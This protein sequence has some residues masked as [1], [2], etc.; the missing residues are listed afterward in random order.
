[1]RRFEMKTLGEILVER[2]I[3]TRDQLN[4]AM[5]LQEPGRKSGEALVDL[6]II[7][8][9]EFEV[10][11]DLLLAEILVGLG[12]ADERAIFGSSRIGVLM[13]SETSSP[14]DLFSNEGFSDL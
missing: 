2:G 1:M 12:Y 8:P 7:S 14:M 5:R 4:M 10:T 3:V 11:L 13:D 6:G 9:G